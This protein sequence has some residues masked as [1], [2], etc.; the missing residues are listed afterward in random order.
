MRRLTY[1]G[2]FIAIILIFVSC[3]VTIEIEPAVTYTV[4]YNKNGAQAGTEP[5]DPAKYSSGAYAVI[6]YNTGNLS[7]DPFVFAGWNT[8]ADRTG[9]SCYPGDRFRIT[10]NITLYA[11]WED[12]ADTFS[13]TYNGNGASSGMP[14]V[15]ENNYLA[16]TRALIAGNSGSLANAGYI[17]AGWNTA[18]DGTGTVYFPGDMMTIPGDTVLYADWKT[19]REFNAI[20]YVTDAWYTLDAIMLA[21]SEHCIIYAEVNDGSYQI[22]GQTALEIAEE[23]DRTIHD[24][25]TAAFGTVLDVDANNKVIL[26]LLDIPDGFTGSGGYVAGYFDQTHMFSKT[27]SGYARSNEADM[28]FIDINP[29]TPGGSGFYSTIAHE[30]QHLINC[31]NTVLKDNRSQDLWINEGLS[32]GP[33]IY[34]PAD[35]SRN[36]LTI[37]TRT[38]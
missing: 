18:A 23:Y 5:A 13:L 30:L 19:G 32:S 3:P 25:I 38:R 16:G 33:N 22:N 34:M 15:N 2:I 24:R 1:G 36:G 4:S 28:L 31:S 37:L 9:T 10:K 21:E 26:L 7:N 14:P 6:K 29:Q 20:S 27:V 11:Q 8:A 17:F 12:E 35:I